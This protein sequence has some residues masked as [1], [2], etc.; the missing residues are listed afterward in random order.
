MKRYLLVVVLSSSMLYALP[1]EARQSGLI[2]GVNLSTVTGRVYANPLAGLVLGGFRKFPIADNL[3]IEPQL[4]F[5]MQG[6][7]CTSYTGFPD[8]FIPTTTTASL[9]MY[10]LELPILISVHTLASH[11]LPRGFDF[12]AGPDV[13]FLA[14]LSTS[15]SFFPSPKQMFVGN[16]AP[17]YNRVGLAAEIGGGPNV[18]IGSTTVGIEFK[19]SLGITSVL[20]GTG[21][22]WFNSVWTVMAQVY[23]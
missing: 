6:G 4:L 12:F 23:V 19:Y 13:E 18:M 1:A 10:Y 5:S 3:Y 8:G 14:D 7:Y 17:G 11:F 22:D 21:S 16:N 20:Q 2:A 15:S 9:R